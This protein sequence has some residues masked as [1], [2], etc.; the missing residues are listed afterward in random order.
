MSILEINGLI[1][2]DAIFYLNDKK[3]SNSKARELFRKTE[4]LAT[5][6]VSKGVNEKPVVHVRTK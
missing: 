3:I 2:Q 5:I 1:Q 4:A 6:D